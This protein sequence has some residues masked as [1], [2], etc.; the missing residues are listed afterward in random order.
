MRIIVQRVSSAS[1][2]HSNKEIANIGKGV[3][4]YIGI[5]KNE[6]EENKI[7]IINILESLNL[8]ASEILCLS[9][10]TLYGSF[11]GTKPSFHKAE[12]PEQARK[13]YK[14]LVLLI[15]SKF[16]EVKEGVFQEKLKIIQEYAGETL[17][18]ESIN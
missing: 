14:Q 2:L 1:V 5:G 8:S 4:L 11:K 16:K 7:W 15:K 10:F 9:Q 18:Y 13:Y 17:Y 6:L 12:S 3:V